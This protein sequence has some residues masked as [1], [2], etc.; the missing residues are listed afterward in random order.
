MIQ[1]WLLLVAAVASPA[2]K[3][4]PCETR[5]NLKSWIMSPT[6]QAAQ[7]APPAGRSSLQPAFSLHIE[8]DSIRFIGGADD[9]YT[10]G[11]AFHIGRTRPW[12]FL[13]K[14]MQWL[15]PSGLATESS[16]L[17]VGQTI[18]TPHN[19][20]TYNPP[21]GDRPFAGFLW[22]GAESSWVREESWPDPEAEDLEASAAKA[23]GQKRVTLHLDVGM[24]GPAA[25]SHVSQSSVHVLRES[26]IP[27]GWFSQLGNRPQANAFVR[28]EDRLVRL[29]RCRSGSD[30]SRRLTWFDFTTMGRLAL[31]TTQTYAA[32]GGTAR[33][34]PHHLTGF[35]AN[36]VWASAAPR[37]PEEERLAVALVGGFE[38]RAMVH[39]A[40]LGDAPEISRRTLLYEWKFGLEVRWREWGVSYTQVNRSQEFE[41]AL[42]E[43]PKRHAYAAIEIVRTVP[44]RASSFDWTSLRGLRG[45][46]RL[47]KGRSEVRPG[48]PADPGLSFAG[49]WGL[50]KT[51]WKPLAL[52]WEKTGITR[53]QGPPGSTPCELTEAPC[54]RDTFLLANIFSLG[55]EVRL[56]KRGSGGLALQLRLGAGPA[57]IKIEEIPDAGDVIE[58]PKDRFGVETSNGLGWLAGLRASYALGRS[59]SA[60]GDVAYVDLHLDDTGGQRA[61]YWT[62]TFG[63]QL[64]PWGR[65]HE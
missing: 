27:K 29:R 60:V 26:R 59:V 39:N 19:I 1:G 63:I 49:S 25:L 37:R 7:P 23:H 2:A 31:G 36:V 35:P 16:S 11:L 65:D 53:E 6:C 21:A 42:A 52:G 40:F 55:A 61:S 8:N 56:A 47:G 48:V 32:V 5:G 18:F 20:V 33:L 30:S 43:V 50:E 9:S 38:A 24:I 12:G 17:T 45:N 58:P 14:P 34:S 46:L 3:P 13:K 51:I 22:V 54:H 57:K 41:T 15:K 28:V 44:S 10:Q 64:H 4:S 62:A